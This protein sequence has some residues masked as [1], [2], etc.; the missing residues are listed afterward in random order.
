MDD[1]VV[2]ATS[3]NELQKLV[4]QLNK[5]PQRCNFK[6]SSKKTRVMAFKGKN[7]ISLE[8]VLDYQILELI[9]HFNY[10]RC[11]ISYNYDKDIDNK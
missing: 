10:L 5:T 3:E 9:S 8:T 11:N 7:P 4:Y 1:H 2:L 6:I